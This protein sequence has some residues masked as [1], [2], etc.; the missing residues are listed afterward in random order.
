MQEK[1]LLRIH[2]LERKNRKDGRCVCPAG[3]Q[4]H[5]MEPGD[6]DHV[7]EDSRGSEVG[8]TSGHVPHALLVHPEWPDWF[9]TP[10]P[11]HEYQVSPTMAVVEMLGLKLAL[12]GVRH[13]SLNVKTSV[14]H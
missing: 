3:G 1:N 9:I 10:S 6:H 7:C 13:F 12:D 5:A 2:S 4:G 11:L 14:V 8:V